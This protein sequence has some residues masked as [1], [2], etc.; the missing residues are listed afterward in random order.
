MSDFAVF[1]TGLACGAIIT[2]V[3]VLI[4]QDAK[5]ARDLAAEDAIREEAEREALERAEEKR[6]ANAAIQALSDEERR[7]VLT[8]KRKLADVVR[9]RAATVK[10][11]S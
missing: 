3:V 4:A 9:A 1:C 2:L 5:R 8:G 11:G 10:L 6:V 7:D